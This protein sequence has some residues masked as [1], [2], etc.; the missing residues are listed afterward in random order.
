MMR[1]AQLMLFLRVRNS[2]A[3]NQL[4]YRLLR[5]LFVIDRR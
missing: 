2:W 5:S 1:L 3:R 4:A